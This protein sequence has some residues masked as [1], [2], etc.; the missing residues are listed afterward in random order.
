[1]PKLTYHPC[2]NARYTGDQFCSC[3]SGRIR[4]PVFWNDEF[5][6]WACTACKVRKYGN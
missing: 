6:G 4:F 2:G 1:M 5:V 3:G